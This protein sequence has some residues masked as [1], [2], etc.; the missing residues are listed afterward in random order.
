MSTGC[1]D[2]WGTSFSWMG[3]D[4]ME[5]VACWFGGLEGMVGEFVGVKD[6]TSG[7]GYVM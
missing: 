7:C 6:G 5:R 1:E 2:L 3:M 4:F